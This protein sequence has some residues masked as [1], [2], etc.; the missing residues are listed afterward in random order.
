M[1][2]RQT[3]A[4]LYF[5][6]TVDLQINGVVYRPSICYKVPPFAK[7]SLESKPSV[8]FYPTKVRFVNGAVAHTPK[9]QA[10]TGVSSYVDE[11]K[12][13]RKKSK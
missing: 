1:L 8:T 4:V 11:D 5:S 7:K 6:T 12:Q 2:Q 13:M 3:E 10:V 9:E